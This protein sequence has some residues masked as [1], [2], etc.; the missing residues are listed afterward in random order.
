MLEVNSL[1]FS[2]SREPILKNI[3]LT[4][5]KNSTCAIIG[6]SGCGKTTLL[7]LL[8]G[9]LSNY[10]GEIYI[11][12]KKLAGVR[13]GTGILLQNGGL[14]P[15]KTVWDNTSLGLKARD[16]EKHQLKIRVDSMLKELNILQHSHKFPSQLSGGEKQ[17]VAIART[18]V[19]QPDLLLL[20]E[21][22][23]ALD[24][25][26]REYFQDLILRLYK[27]HKLTLIMVTHSIEEAVFL[28]EKIVVMEKG[29]I[30]HIIENPYFGDENI[31][32]SPKYY[33][34]CLQVR[35]WLKEDSP[36]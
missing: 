6:A 29:H 30:K 11:D 27:K 32:S 4:I 36:A 21:P 24:A 17:R 26:N 12:K 22:S 1:S 2:Y 35:S 3:N 34:V 15:W 13:K 20:D 10:E 8:A 14:L 23:S 28:G 31:R 9:L 16:T 19:L 18:L 33:E 5:N 25:M 7:Y